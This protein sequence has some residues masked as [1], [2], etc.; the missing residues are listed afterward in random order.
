[1]WAKNSATKTGIREFGKP[2][3]PSCQSSCRLRL[4]FASVLI[5]IAGAGEGSDGIA[6][7]FLYFDWFRFIPLLPYM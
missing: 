5:G 1:M 6:I 2:T 3:T 7:N 4:L